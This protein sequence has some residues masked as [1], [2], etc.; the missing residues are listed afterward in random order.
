M[1]TPRLLPRCYIPI[2]LVDFLP[3][4]RQK[5]EKEVRRAKYS[6]SRRQSALFRSLQNPL[7]E[8]E[9]LI[10]GEYQNKGYG[11]LL[12]QEV[13][14]RVRER[15]AQMIELVCPDDAHHMHFYGGFGMAE[16]TNLK[17]M[18]KRL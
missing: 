9:I 6:E 18:K 2:K 14:Q 13:E 1:L 3:R 8:N 15:G 10:F 16:A 12:L 7:F 11:R 4:E 5:L 17:L